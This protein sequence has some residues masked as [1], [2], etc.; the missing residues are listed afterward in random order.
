MPISKKL[1]KYLEAQG[2]K[3]DVVSHRT[4]FT[5]YDA[6]ATLK[7]ELH[8]IA[9]TL[10]IA[11]D[12]QLVLAV[13]PANKKLDL[14]KIKKALKATKVVIASE[15][16]LVAALKIKPGTLSAFGSLHKLQVLADDS[17]T[18]AKK[19]VLSSGSTTDSII[20]PT[21]AYLKLEGAKIAKIAIGGG[22]TLPKLAKKK[23]KKKKSSKKA[24]KKGGKKQITAKASTKKKSAKK[25]AKKKAK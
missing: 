2:A 22:Y 9:K 7:R 18:K 14:E 17:L 11:A 25:V 6:A 8:E 12:K 5:A 20:M 3:F 24:V 23:L 10:L 4:V 13:V 1:T 16:Q 19:I 21:V 15:K